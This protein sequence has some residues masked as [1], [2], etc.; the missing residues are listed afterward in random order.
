MGPSLL[1]G[2]LLFAFYAPTI[3]FG[4]YR[5]DFFYFALDRGEWLAQPFAAHGRPVFTATLVLLGGLSQSAALHH[6]L[7]VVL[8]AALAPLLARVARRLELPAP[9]L[10]LAWVALCHPAFVWPASWISQR[11]DLLLLGFLCLA[12]AG[13]RSRW[14]LVA[15]WASVAAKAPFVFHAAYFAGLDLRQRRPASALL[16]LGFAAFC[17]FSVYRSYYEVNVAEAEAGLY[18][19]RPEGLLGLVSVAALRSLK[20][21]EGLFTTFLPIGAF[22]VN[23]WLPLLALG[24]GVACWG[25]L[26]FEAIPG[27]RRRLGEHRRGLVPPLA[28]GLLLALPY[29]FSAHLRIY[30]PA[31]PMLFMAV[32]ALLPDTLRS[33]AALALLTALFLAGSLL[34]YEATRTGCSSLELPCR[35]EREVPA[36]RWKEERQRWVDGLVRNLWANGGSS[37][38][39]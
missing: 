22:A 36:E 28:L 3:G 11:S 8:F 24:L 19:A 5:D 37:P 20:I 6:A 17:L 4:Y 33:R 2:G 39:R 21:A 18:L 25:L 7:N 35:S 34:N 15:L 14:A 31:A 1:V 26:L 12:V 9:G 38:D 27:L 23:G 13:W 16:L 30:A 29:A 32:G 10:W